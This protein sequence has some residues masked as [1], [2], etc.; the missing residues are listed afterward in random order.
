LQR[1]FFGIVEMIVK[2]LGE[3]MP[4]EFDTDPLDPSKQHER[5]YIPAGLAANVMD[6]ARSL[7][8][9]QLLPSDTTDSTL[10]YLAHKVW[11]KFFWYVHIKKWIPF[12]R[13]DKCVTFL[14]DLLA[15]KTQEARAEI[16]QGREFHVGCCTLFRRRYELRQAL[17]MEFPHLFCSITIDAMDNSKT[18]I[19]KL[20]GTL[21]SKK[22]DNVGQTMRF[23]LMGVI[24]AGWMF[25][26][27]W[28][29]PHLKSNAAASL[30][31][32]Q[33][34]FQI[35]LDRNGYLPPVLLVQADNSGRD[36]KNQYRM[37][38]LAWLVQTGVFKE[39]RLYFLTVGHTHCGIDQCFSQVRLFRSTCTMYAVLLL[40]RCPYNRSAGC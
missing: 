23:E 37:A 22:L 31:V 18:M 40:T 12:A 25:F 33:R 9:R 7:R 1:L 39:V 16:R 8:Q 4:H 10:T 14:N 32:M 21:Y 24:V 20:T 13:C 5:V 3:V 26:G 36:N 29:M 2:D 11:P 27:A 15:A 19:P 17:G 35:L 6:L 34:T 28:I 30:T 38:Y